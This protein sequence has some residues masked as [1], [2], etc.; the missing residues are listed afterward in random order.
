MNYCQSC[1]V[2]LTED[3]MYGTNEDGSRNEDYCTYCY[4]NGEFIWD[5]TMD[6]MI[7]FCIEPTLDM[8]VYPDAEAA[9][10]D[11]LRTFPKLKRWQK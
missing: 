4:E 11:M 1:S 9:R 6:E 2:P 10:Q 7:E 5:C 3:D 8:K